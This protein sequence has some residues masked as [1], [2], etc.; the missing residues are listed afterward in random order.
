[1][2]SFEASQL[3][4]YYQNTIAKVFPLSEIK[5]NLINDEVSIFIPISVL[6]KETD[7]IFSSKADIFF[8]QIKNLLEKDFIQ[9]KYVMDFIL[10]EDLISS[11]SYPV[12]E[13]ITTQRLEKVDKK[14]A[15]H[16]ILA[17][18]YS[19]GIEKGEADF[20]KLHFRRRRDK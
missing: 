17:Q 1:M 7:K 15:Q 8:N 18:N 14:M 13:H 9:R 3:A 4:I 5:Q 12:Y 10:F 2:P 11:Q 6:F 16:G 19:V 20:F